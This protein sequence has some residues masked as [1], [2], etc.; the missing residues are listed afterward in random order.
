MEALRLAEITKQEQ[1]AAEKE[2]LRLAEIARKKKAETE[3]LAAI[4]KAKQD[5][6]RKQK[7]AESDR[8]AAAKKAKE[9]KEFQE[10]YKENRAKE[11]KASAER[12][13][14]L[15][16]E[17]SRPAEVYNWDCINERG[18]RT[19]YFA[20]MPGEPFTY[21]VDIPGNNPPQITGTMRIIYEDDKSYI[22]KDTCIE[23]LL[24]KNGKR[25][26]QTISGFIEIAFDCISH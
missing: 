26:K 19:R 23:T 8:L 17:R 15:A 13:R 25:G 2:R 11:E 21:I 20:Q 4:E 6:I 16:E 5:E 22:L 12:K 10:W 18:V 24:P 9:D 7:Q 3:R 1:A 14:K